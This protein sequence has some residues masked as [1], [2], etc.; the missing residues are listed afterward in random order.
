MATT[1]EKFIATTALATNTFAILVMFFVSNSILGPLVDI[2]DRLS[3]AYPQVFPMADTTYIIGSIW[4]VLFLFEIMCVI[5]FVVVVA[6]RT[7]V[8][9]YV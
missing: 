5:G 8:D 4:V 9:D 7:V 2:V 1:Q 3:S 6:R